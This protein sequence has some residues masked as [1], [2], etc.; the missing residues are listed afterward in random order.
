MLIP[1]DLLDTRLE[2]TAMGINGKATDVHVPHK[3]GR[4]RGTI[5]LETAADEEHHLQL[6]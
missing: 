2:S 4:Q 3:A 5:N 6:G 1:T